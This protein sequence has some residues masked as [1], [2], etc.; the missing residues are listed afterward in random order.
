MQVVKMRSEFRSMALVCTLALGFA[1]G[2]ARADYPSQDIISLNISNDSAYTMT[3]N[4]ETET[5]A[6]T[7]PDNA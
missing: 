1:G 4:G 6:G 2:A 5:L 7:L 3:G